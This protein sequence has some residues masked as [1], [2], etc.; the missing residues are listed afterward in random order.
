MMLPIASAPSN[1]RA[2]LGLRWQAQRDTAFASRG[3]VHAEA[4]G[5][6]SAS[7]DAKAPSPLRFAGAV[8]SAP[9]KDICYCHLSTSEH[10]YH[11]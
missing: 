3:A 11:C 9:R 10:T 5:P 6:R 8:Q 2:R 7:R 1:T 4:D